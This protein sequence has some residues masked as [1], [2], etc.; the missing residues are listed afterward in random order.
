MLYDNKQRG[1]NSRRRKGRT[2]VFISETPADCPK[3][4]EMALSMPME[5]RAQPTIVPFSKPSNLVS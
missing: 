4:A 2:G 1:R 3:T 5:R